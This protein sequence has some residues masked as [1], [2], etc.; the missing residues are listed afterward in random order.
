MTDLRTEAQTAIYNALNV[1]AVTALA[2]VFQHVPYNQVPPMIIIGRISAEPM[3]GK[4]GGL[5]RLTCEVI[6]QDRSPNREKLYAMMGAIRTALDGVTLTS[7]AALLTSPTF[8]G[9][10]D[11]LADD[12][13][14]YFGSQRFVTIAQPA[15]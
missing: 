5:D 12:G 15:A 4:G 2:P 9:S 6:S 11:D 1:P 3:G 8:E 10:D 14:T 13:E 7:A